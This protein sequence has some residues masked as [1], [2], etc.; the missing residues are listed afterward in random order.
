[1]SPVLL[2]LTAILAACLLPTS[3]AKP[4][5]TPPPSP[6]SPPPPLDYALYLGALVWSLELVL[7]EARFHLL[8]GQWDDYLLP[9]AL[10]FFFLAYRFDNRFVLSLALTSLA[11]WFGLT[12]AL[13]FPDHQDATYRHSAIAYC[14]VVGVLA[15]T[16]TRARIKPHFLP[17]YLNLIANVL[18][19][20]LLAGVFDKETSGLWFA[21]L[22]IACAAS[23]LWG[24][25][26][27]QF[28]F[29]AYAAL[30]AYIAVSYLILDNS[31]LDDLIG[32]L[33]YFVVSATA[34]IVALVFIAR[35]LAR[36]E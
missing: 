30:Y 26:Q 21:A 12:I 13:R 29:I 16:L 28:P 5:P 22:L 4:P 3:S 35:R 14:I 9:T 36:S 24:Y 25:K 34:M 1:M 11:G 17:T 32:I 6:P 8:S 31:R 20:A 23:G 18:L 27:R 19:A 15:L 10:L 33:F 2:L 7:I